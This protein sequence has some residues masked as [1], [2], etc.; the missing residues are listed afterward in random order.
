MPLQ[1]CRLNN[2]AKVRYP[3]RN[4]VNHTDR[5][6]EAV[7]FDMA[8]WFVPTAANYFSRISKDS[9]IE[10][11][12]KVKGGE[13]AAWHSMKKAELAILAERDTAEIGWLPTMLHIPTPEPTQ[14]Q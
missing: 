7:N 5:L 3:S 4:Q 13:A 2:R 9:I 6:T 12:R 1:Q 11:L 14:T 10:A 8:A